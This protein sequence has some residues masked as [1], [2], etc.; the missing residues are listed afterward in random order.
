MDVVHL[1]LQAKRRLTHI[2]VMDRRLVVEDAVFGEVD[3]PVWNPSSVLAERLVREHRN[4]DIEKPTI[5]RKRDV[6]IGSELVESCHDA[7]DDICH[8]ASLRLHV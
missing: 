2:A 3:A 4:V 8:S 7:G 1:A 6:N 5:V